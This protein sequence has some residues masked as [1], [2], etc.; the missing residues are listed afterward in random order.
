[1][2]MERLTE[3][4]REA[5][6]NAHERAV[7]SDHQN[8]M[9]L[10][11]LAAMLKQEDGLVPA[12]LQKLEVSLADFGGAVN[13]ELDGDFDP[14]AFRHLALYNDEKGRIEMHLVS[15]ARQTVRIGDHRIA[16]ADGESIHTE[17]S[18][19]YT[20]AEFQALAGRAEFAASHVWVDGDDL[21]GIHHMQ[22]C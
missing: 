16:F 10:H 4:S 22:A 6:S 18:Y 17:N 2:N 5:V 19:K 12:L 13:R 21:F 1:M 14:R 15:L 20:V 3:R 9:P 8:L 7:K 11:L